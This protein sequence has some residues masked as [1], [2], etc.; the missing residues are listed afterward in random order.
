MKLDESTDDQLMALAA[1][2][3][4]LGRASYIVG[5]CQEWIRATWDDFT[6]N[7]RNVIARD[8][9]EA[10]MDGLCGMEMDADGWKELMEWAWPRLD[11]AGRS[12]VRSAVAWKRKPWPLDTHAET[13][14]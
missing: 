4:C 6:A 5:A 14:P 3:Y 8:T 2:R 12:F 1:H 10:L 13:T 11:D 9:V 7:T